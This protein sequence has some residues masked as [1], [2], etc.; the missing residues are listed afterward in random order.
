MIKKEKLNTDDIFKIMNKLQSKYRLTD[1]EVDMVY[2]KHV[3]EMGTTDIM[4]EIYKEYWPDKKMP[5]PRNMRTYFGNH[6]S[7]ASV[8]MYIQDLYQTIKDEY[9]KRNSILSLGERME[10]LSKVVT[11]EIKE[12]GNPKYNCIYQ[13][14]ADIK[15]KLQ[16]INILNDFDLKC[17]EMNT[18]SEVIIEIVGEPIDM[19]AHK[20]AVN[21]PNLSTQSDNKVASNVPIDEC[22]KDVMEDAI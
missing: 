22:F 13:K 17:K 10:F 14:E 1:V 5:D 16:A 9:K 21:N 12:P 8:K 3:K 18:G 4:R 6:M 11:G 20:H 7:K 15:T 19:N 2:L